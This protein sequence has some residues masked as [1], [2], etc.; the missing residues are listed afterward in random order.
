MQLLDQPDKTCHFLAHNGWVMGDDP[1]RNF[2]ELGKY[3]KLPQ[4]QW[5]T[6]P[7]V[8]TDKHTAVKADYPPSGNPT[9]TQGT[10]L[11]LFWIGLSVNKRPETSL[12]ATSRTDIELSA[13][14]CVAWHFTLARATHRVQRVP[15][16][17]ADLLGWQRQ[18]PL[19]QGPWRL[20]IP[21]GPHEE[22]HRNHSPVFPWSQTGQ[23]PLHT[24]A[25]RWGTAR[26]SSPFSD[27]YTCTDWQENLHSYRK[28]SRTAAPVIRE[29]VHLIVTDGHFWG[30]KFAV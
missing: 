12:W 17:G 26:L 13:L 20:S 28:A 7:S 29:D 27:F 22:V 4:I 18:T 5:C 14:S 23:L 3:V 30:S 19:W 8:R 25:R 21:V 15:A 10:L 2:A 1:L 16:P 6:R 9:Q 24:P 11:K